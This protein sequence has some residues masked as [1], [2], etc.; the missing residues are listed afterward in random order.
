LISRALSLRHRRERRTCRRRMSVRGFALPSGCLTQ[1]RHQCRLLAEPG[2]PS[3]AP[4]QRARLA[5]FRRRPTAAGHAAGH[6]RAVKR[7]VRSSKPASRGRQFVRYRRSNFRVG[8]ER[9]RLRDTWTMR[10][11]RR[12][13]FKLL[14]LKFVFLIRR[15]RVD[16]A[17]RRQR[18]WPRSLACSE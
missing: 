9:S 5:K 12:E 2:G 17:G 8:E 11:E 13:R 15:L 3:E 6:P 7:V 18:G 14:P 4:A 16:A 1:A 10:P